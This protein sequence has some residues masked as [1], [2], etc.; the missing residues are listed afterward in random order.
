MTITNKHLV[1]CPNCK[2][3]SRII[4]VGLTQNRIAKQRYFCYKCRKQF[5]TPIG[6][7]TKPHHINNSS[8]VKPEDEI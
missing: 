2:T 3:T 6:T 7:S 5:T 1:E 4:K 8:G